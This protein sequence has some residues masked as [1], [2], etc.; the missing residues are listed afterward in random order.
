M[1]FPPRQFWKLGLLGVLIACAGAD[2]ASAGWMGFRNDTKDTLVIQETIIINGQPKAGRPQRLFAGEAVRDAQFIGGQRLFSVYDPKNPNKP[3]YTGNFACPPI[4]EN[5][6]YTL[7][8]DG[9]G[10]LAV[11]AVK[12]PAGAMGQQPK[13][14][15]PLPKK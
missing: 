4:N 12:A 6:L 1:S 9:K 10:G 15:T 5:I 14:I 13:A 11:E 3:V 8:S 2:S 7:K